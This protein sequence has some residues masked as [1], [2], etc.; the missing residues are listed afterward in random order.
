MMHMERRR[1][2]WMIPALA[3][4]LIGVSLYGFQEHRLQSASLANLE[5]SYQS[6]FHSMTYDIDEL[7]D[8][9]GN[10]LIPKSSSAMIGQLHIAAKDAATAEAYASRMPV[11][12]TQNSHLQRFLGSV[13]Q[14]TERLANAHTNGTAFSKKDRMEISMLYDQATQVERAT[15]KAQ[16]EMMVHSSPMIHVT[17]A[18][19]EPVFGVTKSVQDQFA[20]I[21]KAVPAIGTGDE[22]TA[23]H[24]KSNQ[25]VHPHNKAINDSSVS[26]STAKAYARFVL[27]DNRQAK[28]SVENLGPG[29]GVNG[30]LVKVTQPSHSIPSY[31][32]VKKSDGAILWMAREGE[33]SSSQEKLTLMKGAKVAQRFIQNQHINNCM[34]ISSVAY[35]EVGTY[36]FAPIHDGVRMLTEPVLVKVSLASGIVTH[37]DATKLLTA[38][39]VDI[40]L[41]N[42]LTE[43][44]VMSE[45]QPQYHISSVYL[46][47]V[48]SA[49]HQPLLVY[50]MMGFTHEN[51]VHVD[52]DAHT[53]QVVAIHKLTKYE[54]ASSH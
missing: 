26:P 14:Q 10:A 25:H 50:D 54:I 7:Q 38:P 52:I 20:N 40:A 12:L 44:Q 51:E 13:T 39:P 8:A 41:Q 48:E 16:S 29:Y 1:V 17:S 15:R 23:L 42:L 47:M 49:S 36:T 28:T 30:Y 53:G 18:F 9:L 6:A 32:A 33:N 31:V 37:Y 4:G 19:A 43:K 22:S 27:G 24:S 2:G 3:L 21:A 5:L 34:L 45:L 46:A 11:T 35:D